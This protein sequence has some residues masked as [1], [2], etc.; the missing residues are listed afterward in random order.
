MKKLNS[1]FNLFL[2]SLFAILGV[3]LISMIGFVGEGD[4]LF[5]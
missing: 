3:A 4:R 5:L 2:V 1:H